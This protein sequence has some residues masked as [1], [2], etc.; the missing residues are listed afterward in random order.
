MEPKGL[1]ANSLKILHTE[2]LMKHAYSYSKN[3][4]KKIILKNRP[5]LLSLDNCH[6]LLMFLLLLKLLGLK[7]FSC[8]ILAIIFDYT[9]FSSLGYLIFFYRKIK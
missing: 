7:H 1:G 9:F 2:D 4:F 6:K 8:I 3:I 5:K